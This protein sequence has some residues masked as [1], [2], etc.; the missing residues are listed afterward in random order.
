MVGGS[1]IS[2]RILS[3]RLFSD[4][5]PKGPSATA[6]TS[7]D[8]V[9]GEPINFDVA[10]KVEGNESQIV[11]IALEPGQ[12]LRAESGAMMYMEEGV[13]MNTTTG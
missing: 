9:V 11:T 10:A 7:K 2:G 5:V 8:G 3:T 12:V 4:V 13:A 6:R 1:S